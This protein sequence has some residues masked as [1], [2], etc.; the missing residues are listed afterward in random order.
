M[1]FS[2]H[3][4]PTQSMLLTTVHD[5]THTHTHARTH[6]PTHPPTHTHTH[7]PAPEEPKALHSTTKKKKK[8]MPHHSG[9]SK[10]HCF[11]RENSI[12]RMILQELH[13]SQTIPF[14]ASFCLRTIIPLSPKARFLS[15]S[16]LHPALL[17]RPSTCPK[18]HSVQR[19]ASLSP[20]Q[21]LYSVASEPEGPESSVNGT[22]K[23]CGISS[24]RIGPRRMFRVYMS[25]SPT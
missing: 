16:L 17:P 13:S 9:H 4:S 7:T 21:R 8:G 6:A 19:I 24:Y 3:F 2:L 11:E 18:K 1:T 23:C 25:K 5:H 10:T 20:F 15:N 12:P 14:S 22:N